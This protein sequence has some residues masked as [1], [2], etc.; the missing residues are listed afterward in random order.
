MRSTT[1]KGLDDGV[2]IELGGNT[3]IIEAVMDAGK[4]VDYLIYELTLTGAELL[5]FLAPFRIDGK[6]TAEIKADNRYTVRSYDW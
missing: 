5:A 1:V 4:G 3:D 2:R 6:L